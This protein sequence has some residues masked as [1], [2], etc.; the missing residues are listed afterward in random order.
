VRFGSMKVRD[1]KNNEL[2]YERRDTV[3]RRIYSFVSRSVAEAPVPVSA[4]RR[5]GTV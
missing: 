4:G 1:A 5:V 3:R 2:R